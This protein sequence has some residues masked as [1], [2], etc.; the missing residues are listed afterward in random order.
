MWATEGN[1]W[2]INSETA[3]LKDVSLLQNF[4]TLYMQICW[5]TKNIC[6]GDIICSVNPLYVAK[7]SQTHINTQVYLWII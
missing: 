1:K 7:T 4:S 5:C 2:S 6:N 3:E